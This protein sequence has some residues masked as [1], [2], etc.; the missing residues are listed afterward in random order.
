MA[1]HLVKT[2][3]GGSQSSTL[4]ALK[5]PKEYPRIGVGNFMSL[6]YH[7]AR[8]TRPVQAVENWQRCL[9]AYGHSTLVRRGSSLIPGMTLPRGLLTPLCMK[10]KKKELKVAFKI[11]EY[12]GYSLLVVI[13]ILHESHAWICI[14]KMQCQT[15]NNTKFPN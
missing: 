5:S 1:G 2:L 15:S 14:S 3:K 9:T 13:Y 11:P 4:T 10:R 12:V 7:S 8:S 6:W